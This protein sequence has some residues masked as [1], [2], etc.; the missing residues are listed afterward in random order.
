MEEREHYMGQI[1]RLQ[2]EKDAA[3]SRN[4]DLMALLRSEKAAVESRLKSQSN[5]LQIKEEEL[6]LRR[7]ELL[8][9]TNIIT[10][11]NAMISNLQRLL[12]EVRDAA[13]N[14]KELIMV[15]SPNTN[16]YCSA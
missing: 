5:F 2:N 16:T 8:E 7:S 3:L 1:Q 11:R 6:A 12:T 9:A 4:A 13:M 15:I 14:S 10:T